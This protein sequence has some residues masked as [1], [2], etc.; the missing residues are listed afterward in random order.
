M[1]LIVLVLFVVELFYLKFTHRLIFN[2]K[3]KTIRGA[4]NEHN[5]I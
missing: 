2:L 4:I 5:K 3:N 1:Q